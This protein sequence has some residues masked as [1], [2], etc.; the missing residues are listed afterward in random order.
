MVDLKVSNI[1][2]VVL[3]SHGD[4]GKTCI[5][6]G[7]LYSANQISRLGNIDEGTT[8]SDFSAEEIERKI[9]INAT[10]MHCFWNDFKINIIDTPGFMD[11]VGEVVGP[12][13]V[14]DAA[15]IPVNA[16]SGIGVGTEIIWRMADEKNM[17]RIVII[18][19]LDKENT[20]FFK[21]IE[22]SKKILNSNLVPVEFP[23][24]TGDG[25][26]SII[27]LISMKMIKYKNDS[28]GN[29]ETADIP[30]D[31]KSKADGLRE[32][33]VESVAENDDEL[34]EKYFEN[35][36]L[37]PEEFKKGLKTG[38]SSGSF[39]PVIASSA[40]K[41]FGPKRLLD[42]IVNYF[43]APD[44]VAKTVAKDLKT[45]EDKEINIDTS[46]PVSA[47][48]F[49][50]VSEK[51]VGELSYFKV[52]SGNAKSGSDLTNTNKDKGERLG[53]LFQMN[54]K[55]RKET[56]SFIAGDIGA[57]VK[58][59]NTFTGDSLC[60]PKNQI[61]FKQ[62]EF[63]LPNIS[64]AVV[65]RSKG[66]EDKIASGLNILKNEDP[67]FTVV[68]DPELRQTIL[69]GQGEQHMDVIIKKLS[70]KFNVDVDTVDPKI[71]YRETITG[72]AQVQY[73]HKKQSGGR[74]QYGEVYIEL[75]PLPRGGGYEF[76]NAIF[77]GSIPSK[78][79]PAVEKGVKESLTS[80]VMAGN[81]VVDVKVKL[82]D[83]TYHNVDSSDMAF[84]IAGSMAFKKA[85][86]ECKPILLEPIYDVEIRVPEEY[87]GDVMGD[88]SSR[89]GKI[90]GMDSEGAIQVIKAKVPLAEMHRYSSTLRSIS[91]G[92]GYHRMKFFHYEQVPHDVA[93]KIIQEVE[94]EKEE[95]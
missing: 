15:L 93:E 60:D 80:G 36:D 19:K 31:L 57:A 41:N 68:S 52:I 43:P 6:E 37:S 16:T 62:L 32:K 78:Y 13:R 85:F 3:L 11:F 67:S 25:F 54:G 22:D 51:H 9:S 12:V 88:M 77:G 50:T 10:I 28:S 23:V 33:L 76:E 72:T 61:V 70:Q 46:A 1:R 4:A 34:M 84:K 7:L 82:Y 92:R 71:P 47:F 55:D 83:G 21:V 26:D 87:M 24:K 48:V 27:D 44:E 14:S 90:Q 66:D 73:K 58:L 95:Q 35:G 94:K 69:S 30:G 81:K 2:N 38:V 49:K 42:F 45:K 64:V 75:S 89:R 39:I 86:R 79:V 53:Q 8:T 40:S 74:G 17:P 59:K 91:S 18:N 63:P 5:S 29:F 56:G 65:P 20:D